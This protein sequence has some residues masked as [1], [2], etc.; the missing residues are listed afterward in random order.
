MTWLLTGLSISEVVLKSKL[1]VARPNFRPVDDA[2]VAGA[3]ARRRI[4]EHWIVTRILRFDAELDALAPFHPPVLDQGHVE[5]VDPRSADIERARRGAKRVRGRT[6]ERVL[7]EI[8]V[9]PVVNRPWRR[10][11][12]DQVR[13]LRAI[14]ERSTRL[15]DL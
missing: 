14:P 1:H 9:Q 8:V 11:V 13:A 2:E 3:V 7:V 4:A 5:H 15:G 12:A 10:R 6:R